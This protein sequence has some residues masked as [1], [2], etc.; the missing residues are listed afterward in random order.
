MSSATTALPGTHAF[1]LAGGR[2]ERLHPLTLSRPKPLLPF[3]G[4]FRIIDFTLSNCLNSKLFQVSL[5]TQY[6]CE[7]LHAH[8]RNAWIDV[9]KASGRGD[10][11]LR[12][13]A[14][15]SGK[16]YRGT[17][18]AVFQNM[19]LLDFDRPEFVLVLAGD[20]VYEI[21]YRDLIR[22]HAETGADLTIAAVEYPVTEARHFGVL[23]A[24]ARF[25]VIGFEEK[26][27]RPRPLPDRP[28]MALVSMGVYVFKADALFRALFKH[29]GVQRVFD[30]GHDVI[31]EMIRSYQVFAYDFREERLN[32][33]RYWRDIGT[34]DSYYEACM[35]LVR[36]R[37]RFN[38]MNDGWPLR[39]AEALRRAPCVARSAHITQSVVSGGVHIGEDAFVQKCVLMPGAHIGKGVRLHRAI[40]EENVAVP[41]GF[42]AGFDLDHDRATHA[43]TEGGVVVVGNSPRVV[44]ISADR[45]QRHVSHAGA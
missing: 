19:P 42:Q 21:D 18:D 16:R 22:N 10:G 28:K 27:T 11:T 13:L 4:F 43:V 12:C 34:V 9:W 31:P 40:V 20:H 17:A 35:D 7:A 37:P 8:I 38:A 3:G 15:A 25:Q 5:L 23:E 32:R 41:D 39:S 6:K 29:C 30:F 1:I 45:Q 2:G 44:H 36:P 33:P 24:D 26:P 14:P